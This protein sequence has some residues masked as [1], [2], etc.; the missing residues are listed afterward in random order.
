VSAQ[1]TAQ[2]APE[3]SLLFSAVCDYCSWYTLILAQSRWDLVGRPVDAASP[4]A[5]LNIGDRVP[6]LSHLN[7]D[8]AKAHGHQQ[9]QQ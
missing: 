8:R 6:I 1:K 7:S 9:Y 3:D 2:S 4:E 5:P